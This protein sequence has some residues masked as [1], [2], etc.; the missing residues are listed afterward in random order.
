MI[1]Y[2]FMPPLPL[3][4]PISPL[5]SPKSR[6]V[7]CQAPSPLVYLGR[8][9]SLVYRLPPQTFFLHQRRHPASLPQQ[10][11]QQ[12]KFS[13]SCLTRVLVWVFVF[14]SFP[15]GRA[16]VWSVHLDME[17]GSISG[18]DWGREGSCNISSRRLLW[19]TTFWVRQTY[20]S[21][22]HFLTDLTRSRGPLPW[23]S[24]K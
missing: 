11:F 17:W 4:G 9:W 19:A 23:P 5:Q 20:N 13:F 1:T 21:I 8:R 16:N 22:T 18:L 12:S 7:C 14:N 6:G 10:S 3:G 2:D 24:S 15:R